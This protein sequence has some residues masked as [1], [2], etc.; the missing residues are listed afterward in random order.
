MCL[1]WIGGYCSIS[2]CSSSGGF[3]GKCPTGSVCVPV[4]DKRFTSLGKHWICLQSCTSDSGCRTGHK[5]KCVSV[6]DDRSKSVK[7]CK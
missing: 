3:S 1:P 7:V 2:D 6:K 5:Y 4:A